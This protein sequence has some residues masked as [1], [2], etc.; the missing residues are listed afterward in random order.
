M[1]KLQEIRAKVIETVPE[2][3]E[4]KPG[5]I[6][7]GVYASKDNP[8][9]YV[10]Y[11]RKSGTLSYICHS[12]TGKEVIYP[13]KSTRIIGRTIR[14]ADILLAMKENDASPLQMHDFLCR[15]VYGKWN[16]RTDDLDQ[17]SEETLTF[18]HSILC[19]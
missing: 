11:V 18:I 10:Q 6:V 2:I 3:I 17:Q 15:V 16:L 19:V 7:E 5:C 14:L 9:K 1:T 8:R 4:L 12:K 13:I